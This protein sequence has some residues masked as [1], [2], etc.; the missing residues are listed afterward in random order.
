MSPMAG[1]IGLTVEFL[2]RAKNIHPWLRK[3]KVAH[4]TPKP[5]LLVKFVDDGANAEKIN[6]K[7]EQTVNM[8]GQNTK[9]VTP[10]NTQ[11]GTLYVNCSQS[12]LIERQQSLALRN[13]YGAD[14][15]A[16]KM[17]SMANLPL[18]ASRRKEAVLNF[19]RKCLV[20]KRCE[21]WFELRPQPRFARRLSYI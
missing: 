11:S 16:S 10:N 14:I 8:R 19:A 18:L 1:C 9:I 7:N 13:I 5:I 2:P 15:S 6:L 4:W 20:N 12:V 21:D 17:R 3:S